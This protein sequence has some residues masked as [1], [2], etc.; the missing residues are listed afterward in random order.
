MEHENDWGINSQ[1]LFLNG[2]E[3]E[4]DGKFGQ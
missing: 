1:D 3:E 4:G 2:S